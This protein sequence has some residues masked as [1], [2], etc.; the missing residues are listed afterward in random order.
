MLVIIKAIMILQATL[1]NSSVDDAPNH[2]LSLASQVMHQSCPERYFT[3][4]T[5]HKV[6]FNGR[7]VLME[8]CDFYTKPVAFLQAIRCIYKTCDYFIVNNGPLTVI[9]D[10]GFLSSYIGGRW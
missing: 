4:P 2:L 3:L 10:L 5:T 1:R 6:G 7:S 9:V 8:L